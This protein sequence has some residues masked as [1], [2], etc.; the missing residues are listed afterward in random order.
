M[1]DQSDISVLPATRDEDYY[2]PDGNI[3]LLVGG[4]LFKVRVYFDYSLA[5]PVVYLSL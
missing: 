2:F 3:V 1:S 4:G 5:R